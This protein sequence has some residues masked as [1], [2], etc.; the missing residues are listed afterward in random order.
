MSTMTL[1]HTNGSSAFKPSEAW[2]HSTV[3]EFFLNI[4]WDGAAPPE[5]SPTTQSAAAG[6][7]EPL[8]MEMSVGR[9]FAAI[10]WDGTAI[11]AA[12]TSAS[13]TSLPA[14]GESSF[15]LDEFSDLF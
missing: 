11:A 8:S 4:N 10:N 6:H 14:N 15:T 12:P 7:S 2:L 3:Q 13:A 5:R 1:P 9:F